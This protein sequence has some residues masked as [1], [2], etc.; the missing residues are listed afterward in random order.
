VELQSGA[1]SVIMDRISNLYSVSLLDCVGAEY[2][3]RKEENIIEYACSC[4]GD[5]VQVPGFTLS[6]YAVR[7]PEKSRL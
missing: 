4:I 5:G 1:A 2:R 7:P 6:L 3:A